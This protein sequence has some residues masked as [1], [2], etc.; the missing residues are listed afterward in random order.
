[1]A[2]LP[3]DPATVDLSEARRIIAGGAGL[4]GGAAAIGCW[5][6]R[7]GAVGLARGHPARGR[8]RLGEHARH[9]GTTGV[10]VDPDLYVA[11]GISGAVQH[12]TGLGDPRHIVA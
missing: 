2:L 6:H 11:I 4:G 9:I 8:P 10:T 1:M 12:L 3:A 7:D 5:T